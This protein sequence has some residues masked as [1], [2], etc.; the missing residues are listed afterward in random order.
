MII[1]MPTKELIDDIIEYYSGKT[2]LSDVNFIAEFPGKRHDLP[3]RGKI[4]SVGVDKVNIF[5]AEDAVKLEYNKSPATMRVKMCICAPATTNGADVYNV[6][7]RIL[8]NSGILISLWKVAGIDTGELKYSNSIAGLLLPV[9]IT[10]NISNM[11]GNI[12]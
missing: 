6:L 11:F 9:F 4:V 1:M 8:G 12:A 5:P 7:D 10:F 2:E 3:L